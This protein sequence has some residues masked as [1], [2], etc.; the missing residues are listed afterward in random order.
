MGKY[1]PTWLK[2]AMN[3]YKYTVSSTCYPF[4][5]SIKK[6]YLCMYACRHVGTYVCMYVCMHVCMYLCMY[7]CIY[8]TASRYIYIYIYLYPY[9][10]L[11]T[12]FSFRAAPA[13]EGPKASL[14]KDL[15]QLFDALRLQGQHLRG[16]VNATTSFRDISWGYTF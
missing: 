10:L 2:V 12:P 7:V 15:D 3:P 8:N 14:R 16:L 1:G 5:P 6:V 4:H 9:I 13:P 11:P